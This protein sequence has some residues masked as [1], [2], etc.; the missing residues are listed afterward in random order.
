M[1]N[2]RQ[3]YNQVNNKTNFLIEFKNWGMIL[4]NY[5]LY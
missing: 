2:V 1:Y 3:K 5:K 4:I